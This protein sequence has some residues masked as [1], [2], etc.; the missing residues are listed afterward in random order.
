MNLD[1]LIGTVTALSVTAIKGTRLMEVDEIELGP[2]GA[3]GDRRFFVID[4]RGRMVN[5]K[6]FG[7]L[8]SVVASYDEEAAVLTLVFPGGHELAAPV[9]GAGQVETNFYSVARRAELVDGPFAAALSAHVGQPLR[10]VRTGSAVDRGRDGAATLV[11]RGS[12]GRLAGEGGLEQIDAR[13]FRMLIE[14][15]GI[16]AHAEDAFVGHTVAVGETVLRFNGYVGRCMI[17]TRNPDTGTVDLKTLHMLQSYRGELE[18]DE[19]LPFGV[20]GAVRR[21]GLVRIGDAVR[22]DR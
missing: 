9:T 20:Y 17:T 11:S 15:D 1:E 2:A 16:P 19:P 3:R 5:G 14:I 18:T 10:L 4:E 8:Q 7:E 22:V 13:R 6:Q 12:L 21:P